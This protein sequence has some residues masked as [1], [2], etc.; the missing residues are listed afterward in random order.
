MEEPISIQEEWQE[1]NIRQYL[2]VLRQ[3]YWLIVL[4][5]IVAVVPTAI[6]LSMEKPVYEAKATVLIEQS[7]PPMAD[8]SLQAGPGIDP[9]IEAALLFSRPVMASVLGQLDPGFLNLP[10]RKK[11]YRINAFKRNI[12]MLFHKSKGYTSSQAALATIMCAGGDPEYVTKIV[13]LV[14]NTYIEETRKR[15]LTE[16]SASIEWFGEQ[17]SEMRQKVN[18]AESKFQAFKLEKGIIGL[19]ERKKELAAN[20][21]AASA[22][23]LGTKAERKEAEMV[24]ESLTS[25]MKLGPVAAT[26]AFRSYGSE[27][28]GRIK[29]DLDEAKAELA[30]KSLRF[31]SKHPE[32]LSLKEKIR[33]LTTQLE[34]HE[35]E[36]IK[37][38]K[39]KLKLLRQNEA[40]QARTVDSYKEEVRKL[41]TE[42]L[43]YSILEREVSTSKELYEVL[44][45]RRRRNALSS[46]VSRRQ[47]SIVE[48]AVIPL[49]PVSKKMH[50]KLLVA[51]I[52]GIILGIA[53]AF[54]REYL[55]STLK[56]PEDVERYLGL[57]VAGMIPEFEAKTRSV[58]SFSQFAA[59]GTNKKLRR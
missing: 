58:L 50:L 19:E 5:V 26:P 36:V 16:S 8:E 29:S 59:H 48:S 53:L 30:E 42:G 22:R 12:S 41:S 28:I 17:I 4:A 51:S 39:N 27:M 23:Y 21:G 18:E 47:I 57:W 2:H 38:H 55:E 46:G 3:R 15:E 40:S 45:E 20:V 25:A 31:K 14:T 6:L 24:L 13:N 52:I 37:T 9:E 32:I 7:T 35:N 11:E 10:S 54:L 49:G 44:I 43:Q 1:I 56:T 33:L 34:N